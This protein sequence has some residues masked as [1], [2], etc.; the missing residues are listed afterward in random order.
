MSKQ[1]QFFGIVVAIIFTTILVKVLN[2]VLDGAPLSY[3]L[4]GCGAVLVICALL[5]LLSG[6]K[7]AGR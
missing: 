7:S 3:L 5:A 2:N 4:A 1:A 6:K